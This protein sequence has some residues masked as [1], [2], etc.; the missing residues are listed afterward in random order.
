MSLLM[1]YMPEY[2]SNFIIKQDQNK[3]TTSTRKKSLNLRSVKSPIES[4]FYVINDKE[5]NFYQSEESRNLFNNFQIRVKKDLIFLLQNQPNY[6]TKLNMTNL[7]SCKNKRKGLHRDP[8]DCTK[9][10]Y[11]EN[12][13]SSDKSYTC[14]TNLIFNMNGCYCDSYNSSNCSYLSETYC[15]LIKFKGFKQ[16]AINI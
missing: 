16:K 5:E 12:N 9:Y 7:F 8:F 14:P 13:F 6:F 11:C 4:G 3:A 15:D 10:Y 2:Y 1:E